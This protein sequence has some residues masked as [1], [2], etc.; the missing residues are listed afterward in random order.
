M[1]AYT[2]TLFRTIKHNAGRFAAITFIILLGI[3]FITGLGTLSYKIEVSLSDF[4]NEYS[5]ADIIVKSKTGSIAQDDI[6]KAA[7][8]GG[9][10]DV[11]PITSFD[12]Q[13]DGL[14][15]RMYA[16]PIADATVNGLQLID[17]KMPTAFNEVVVERPS[18]EMEE[19]KTG[20]SI[21]VLGQKMT[22][23]GIVANPL[24]TYKGG[25]TDLVNNNPLEIIAYVDSKYIPIALPYTDLYIKLK[26]TPRNLF[27]A[28]YISCKNKALDEIKSTLGEENF[29]YLTLE[30]NSGYAISDSYNKKVDVI[31]LIFPIF[32]IAVAAL[33]VLTTMSR[34]IEEE[35]PAI[36]CY[37]TLGVSNAKIALKYIIFSAIC[38]LLGCGGGFALGVAVLPTVI[39]PAFNVLFFMP[40]LAFASDITM[41]LIAAALMIASVLGVTAYL[42]HKETKE[43]PANLLRHKAP[44]SGKKIFLEHIPFIWK[45]LSFKYKSTCRNI[46]RY[47]KHLL[48]TVVSVAGSTALVL[49]GFGLMDITKS[50]NLSV[51]ISKAGDSMALIAT[52]IIVFAVA[53]CVLVIFNL[54]N[55]NIG[56]RKREIATLKVL[57]YHDIEVSG[58]IFREVFIMAFMGVIVGIP[59]G[60]GLMVFVFPY[61]DFGTVQDVQ[62]YSYLFAA[63]LVVVVIGIV[64]LLLHA[65]IKKIDMATSLK[66]VE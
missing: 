56:E 48:M 62:W 40:K 61:I 49:A 9:V 63:L 23:T 57:G 55:M 5:V 17:G 16:M 51:D 10:S 58:Y 45:R 41:G 1:S 43:Q 29:A 36:G 46:F 2:K 35:R 47:V 30:E 32:F 21:T 20:D 7:E 59:L 38:C 28:E 4:M 26:D 13:I 8:V 19:M 54:T 53:L 3:S 66:T 27:S 25:E 12:M 18:D 42:I 24:F 39:Y 34:L 50:D 60:Y 44:K 11:A 52:V 65:K 64:D 33:V 15:G 14:N 37:T 6:D 31:A 22:I